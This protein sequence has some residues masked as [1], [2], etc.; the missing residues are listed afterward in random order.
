MASSWRTVIPPDTRIRAASRASFFIDRESKFLELAFTFSFSLELSDFITGKLEEML[1]ICY[2]YG[3]YI[4]IQKS[5]KEISFSIFS[6]LYYAGLTYYSLK[7]TLRDFH[8][9]IDA[10][11]EVLEIR[12]EEEPETKEE[13]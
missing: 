7:E 1:R 8:A 11:K 4:N 12:D 9:C 5:K 13:E 6:K 3:C 2:E 10:L